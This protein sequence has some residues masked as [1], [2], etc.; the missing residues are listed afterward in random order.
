MQYNEFNDLGFGALSITASNDIVFQYN[1][2]LNAEQSSSDAGAIYWGREFDTLGN[3][4]RYNYFENVGSDLIYRYLNGGTACSFFA[5]DASTGGDVYGNIFFNGG[6]GQAVVGNGPQFSRVHNN[7]SICT[8]FNKMTRSFQMRNWGPATGITNTY[9]VTL[10]KKANIGSWLYLMGMREPFGG[11]ISAPI[12]SDLNL[13]WSTTWKTHY[14]GSQWEGALNQYS[15]QM[16]TATKALFDGKDYAGLLTYLKNNMPDQLT[17]DIYAN[18]SVGRT[19]MDSL[20]NHYD[21]YSGSEGSISEADKALFVD[22]D[23][24]DFNLSEEGLKTIR[25]TIPYFEEIPFDEMGLKSQVGGNK[26]MVTVDAKV[27]DTVIAVPDIEISPVYTFTDADGD[28]EGNTKIYW[29]ASETED[30]T[31]EKIY[32]EE[33]KHFS[34][35]EEYVDQYLKY[36][37]VPYDD[38]V[39]R[40]EA[41]WSPPIHVEEKDNCEVTYQIGEH[42]AML[43]NEKELGEKETLVSGTY[44]YQVIPNEGYEVDSV[45]VTSGE[46]TLPITLNANNEFDVTIVKNTT[47]TVTFREKKMVPEIVTDNTILSDTIVD[48]EQTYQAYLAFATIKN[49]EVINGYGMY[50]NFP[51]GSMK[52][53]GIMGENVMKMMMDSNGKFAFRVFGEALKGK[54]VTLL[55]YIAVD[56]VETTGDETEE[57]TYQ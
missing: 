23:H 16:Y 18:V 46:I 15:N 37:I 4:V 38:T 40:G 27:I 55:P 56:D 9:G 41:V 48:G 54:T 30:G 51:G 29:Y 42:G 14:E 44:S 21:N 49:V 5:D 11:N 28:L 3:V 50:L 25:K 39:L 17:S 6:T 45:S 2:V 10:P 35:T 32:S 31:Y 8:E 20:A 53:E 52:L 24:K 26:P 12:Q 36:E 33:G 47:I 13:M 43:K 34:V 1:K 22:F 57:L 19:K 7:I